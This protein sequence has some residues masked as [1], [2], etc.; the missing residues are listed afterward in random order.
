MATAIMAKQLLEQAQAG[1]E[2]TPTDRR[3]VIAHLRTQ[4]P[5]ITQ[6]AMAETFKVTSTTIRNDLAEIAREL[7][8]EA[9]KDFLDR[10]AQDIIAHYMNVVEEVKRGRKA[11]KLGSPTHKGYCDLELTMHLKVI[12]TLKVLNVIG[13][14]PEHN[15][16]R[17]VV[18]KTEVGPTGRAEIRKMKPEEVEIYYEEGPEIIDYVEPTLEDEALIEQIRKDMK[19]VE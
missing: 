14:N 4:D 1:E 10:V 2:L 8:G 12:E 6:A 15:T 5:N 19:V 18:Y 3:L 9:K 11:S 13:Q 16:Q 17:R 7:T